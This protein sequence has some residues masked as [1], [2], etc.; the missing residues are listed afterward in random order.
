M[1]DQKY[2]QIILIDK[3]GNET[4]LFDRIQSK[5]EAV[6]KCMNTKARCL[7]VVRISKKTILNRLDEQWIT[8]QTS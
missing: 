5:K 2:W 1:T 7:K 3:S 6:D 4:V 8:S